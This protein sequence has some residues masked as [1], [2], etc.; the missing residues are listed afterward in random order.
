M[1]ASEAMAEVY[2]LGGDR[3]ISAGVYDTVTYNTT[4]MEKLE[5]PERFI[6]RPGDAWRDSLSQMYP[7]RYQALASVYDQLLKYGDVDKAVQEAELAVRDNEVTDEEKEAIVQ[8]AIAEHVRFFSTP[9]DDD[10]KYIQEHMGVSEAALKEGMKEGLAARLVSR[11]EDPFDFVAGGV[12]VNVK[13]QGEGSRSFQIMDKLIDRLESAYGFTLEDCKDIGRKAIELI[14][15]DEE[16]V[17]LIKEN[18][19]LE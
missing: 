16:Y 5:Q 18:F 13:E 12:S 4:H 19:A 10:I 11:K 6:L 2:H 8:H 1:R 17:R 7:D 9:F 14:H 3:H 15:D